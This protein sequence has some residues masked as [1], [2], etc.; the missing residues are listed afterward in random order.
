MGSNEGLTKRLAA[1]PEYRRQFELV[2]KSEG[3]TIDTIASAI[4]AYERTLP[5]GNSPFDRFITGKRKAITDAQMRGWELFKGKAKCIECHTHSLT[6]PDLVQFM[7]A[8]TSDDVLKVCQTTS[9]QTR[10]AV[11]IK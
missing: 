8:L 9:P 10:I 6:N 1:I 4:A 5:S 3:I 7:R 11:S 2:F